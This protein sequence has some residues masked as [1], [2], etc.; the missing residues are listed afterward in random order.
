M[1]LKG[2]TWKFGNDI[3]TDA[4]IPARYLNTTDPKELAAHCMED[5]DAEF[6]SKVKPGDII[7]AGKNFGC[8]ACRPEFIV[9]P[10][11]F[12]LEVR[13]EPRA[14]HPQPLAAQGGVGGRD[15]IFQGGGPLKKVAVAVRR[16]VLSLVA[17]YFVAISLATGCLSQPPTVR[18]T[19]SDPCRQSHTAASSTPAVLGQP[20][21]PAQNLDVAVRSAQQVR[22][23]QAVGGLHEQ[24]QRV[25]GAI[26]GA[27]VQTRTVGSS[28]SYRPAPGTI[29]QR[30]TT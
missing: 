30:R 14:R 2:K 21:R 19:P 6:V 20:H 24:F 11:D 4:I 18:R 5:A 13:Q 3:D 9:Q 22:L 15:E 7:V 1:K 8:V 26:G 27:A 23:A 17:F 10:E 25:N 16:G 12:L 29:L 28:E